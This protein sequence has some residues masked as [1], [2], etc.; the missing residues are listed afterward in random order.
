[1]K[2]CTPRQAIHS[3]SPKIRSVGSFPA[4]ATIA[5]LG[6]TSYLTWPG[7]LYLDSSSTTSSR[8]YANPF[9]APNDAPDAFREAPKSDINVYNL[10]FGTV[11]GICAG[12]F[13]KKGAKLL[14]FVLGGA[15]V[16]LQVS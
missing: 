4:F 7:T 16:F 6:L 8:G 9:S 15:F 5:G 14:A 10:G 12:V 1:M 2:Q 13:I 3:S 11:C